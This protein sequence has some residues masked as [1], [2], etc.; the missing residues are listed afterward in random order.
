MY[1]DNLNEMDTLNTYMFTC[2]L[3]LV[4]HKTGWYR[5]T[6]INT[7]GFLDIQQLSY[8]HIII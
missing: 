8:V 6:T 4:G 5:R 7:R 3:K 2:D 1:N